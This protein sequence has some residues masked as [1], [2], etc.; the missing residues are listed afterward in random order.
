M[1]FQEKKLLFVSCHYRGKQLDVIERLAVAKGFRVLTGRDLLKDDTITLGL[2]RQIN[3]C[4]HFLGVWSRDGAEQ[5][6]G[7]HWP[8]SWLLW[9]FG[10]AEA[11][12]L[13][14]RLLISRWIA[15]SAWRRIAAHRQHAIFDDFDFET[16]VDEV[17]DALL[18]I[19]ARRHQPRG[20]MNT[21]GI[22]SDTALR[23]LI[24]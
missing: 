23:S 17:L 2:L 16:K 24:H 10:A 21:L 8:S 22:M 15:D 19:P 5:C 20:R 9:E 14:W 7:E 6:R 3:C 11:F 1:P 4:S 18:F 12:G 13:E